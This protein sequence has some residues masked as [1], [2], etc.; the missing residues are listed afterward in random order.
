MRN[1]LIVS[2]PRSG[3]SVLSQLL[4]SAGYR[5]PNVSICNESKIKI[6]ASEFNSAGYNEDSAFTL[7][8]DQL[9]RLLYGKEYSFLHSPPPPSG[10]T[11]AELE[12]IKNNDFDSFYYD[13]EETTVVVPQ[14]YLSRLQEIANHS[15]DV[16]GLSRMD[17]SGKWYKAYSRHNLASGADVQKALFKFNSFLT[18]Q[19][20]SSSIYIKDPR[21]VFA[22]PAYAS[23]IKASKFSII[24]INREPSDLLESMRSHY[25]NRLFTHQCIDNLPFVS[26][27]FNYQVQPQAFAD[28]LTGVYYA[29]GIIKNLGVPVLELAYDKLMK[30]AFRR[31]ELSRLN[32]FI[33]A[34]VDSDILYTPA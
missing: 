24:L 11:G 22:F 28:Y 8:N 26:N 16:W 1:I 29:F 13:L 31:D 30:N 34:E 3:S 14:E 2:P 7:L 25:G 20:A 18:S 9:I 21:I 27:H 5:S 23:A 19:D 32:S 10:I 6:A 4:E 17:S 33:D 12:T 15:W